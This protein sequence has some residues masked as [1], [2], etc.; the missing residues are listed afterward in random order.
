MAIMLLHD[1]MEMHNGVGV[2]GGRK[3]SVASHPLRKTD[4]ASG[5]KGIV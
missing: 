5:M 3:D 2:E 1:T 4:M